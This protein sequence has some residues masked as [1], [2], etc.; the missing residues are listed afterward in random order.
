M[1]HVMKYIW[2]QQKQEVLSFKSWTKQEELERLCAENVPHPTLWTEPSMPELLKCENNFFYIHIFCL[3]CWAILLFNMCFIYFYNCECW[4]KTLLKCACRKDKCFKTWYTLY[5][6]VLF[7]FY[8]YFLRS[9]QLKL[10]LF[11]VTLQLF[12]PWISECPNRSDA[13]FYL[14]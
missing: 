11:T 8:E 13:F 2:I 9:L 4:K 10:L 7:S 12:V 3:W 14:I 5:R 1:L 6:I